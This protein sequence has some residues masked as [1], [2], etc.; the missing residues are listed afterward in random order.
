MN[1]TALNNAN[2]ISGDAALQVKLELCEQ[3][4]KALV[5][6]KDQLKNPL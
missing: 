2:A 4:Q 6:S 1:R 5:T 3:M